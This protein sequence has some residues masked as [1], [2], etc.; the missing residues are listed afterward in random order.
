[1]TRTPGSDAAHRSAV[2]EQFTRQAA[3]FSSAPPIADPTALARIVALSGARADDTMLD[4]AC[5]AGLV[6]LAFAPRVR[7]VT[8]VDAT[9]A[10]LERARE[11]QRAA[12]VTNVTWREGDAARLDFASATF[13]LVVSRFAFHHFLDARA[14]LAEMARVRRSDGAVVVVDL[15]P[16]PEKRDAFDALDRLRDPSHAR[17]LTV[18]ELVRAFADVG[19]PRPEVHA[20]ALELELESHLARSFPNPGDDER[21]REKVRAALGDDAPGVTPSE[22]PEGVVRYRYPYSIAVAR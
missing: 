21:F 6:A 9:P 11:L 18:D 20:D 2:V 12:G 7:H 10:M 15:T 17:S 4:V 5:G 19:L 22:S 13:S 3:P 16:A 14:V 1:M 8:G